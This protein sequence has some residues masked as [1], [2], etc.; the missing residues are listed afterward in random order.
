MKPLTDTQVL[1]LDAMRVQC[2]ANVVRYRKSCP[3]LYRDDLE[4]IGKGD[5]GSVWG[6][7]C[8]TWQSANKL[9]MTAGKVL[10]TFKALEA[11]GLVI[12]EDRAV[13]TYQRPLYWWPVGLAAELVV[14]LLP[15]G[16]GQAGHAS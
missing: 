12:R 14:E 9:G 15:Q 1:V 6:L 13:W 4:R 7:G 8:L 2:R 3:H 10:R 16:D 11:R 5:K